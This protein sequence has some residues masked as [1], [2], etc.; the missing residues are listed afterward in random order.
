MEGP[1]ATTIKSD[2]RPPTRATGKRLN[3]AGALFE[4]LGNLIRAKPGDGTASG[5]REIAQKRR[6][7]F[8]E[9]ARVDLLLIAVSPLPPAIRT[10]PLAATGGTTRTATSSRTGCL[11][12]NSTATPAPRSHWNTL[13]SVL[14]QPYL[15]SHRITPPFGSTIAYLIWDQRHGRAIAQH[16]RTWR[17]RGGDRRRRGEKISESPNIVSLAGYSV[18]FVASFEDW[19]KH[20]APRLGASL[21]FY[22][23]LSLA[24]LLLVLVS[25]VGLVLG[26]KRRKQNVA[27]CNPS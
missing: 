24:P 21:A 16:S 3:S 22:T 5:A 13:G 8:G 7:G 6:Q 26:T 14:K 9:A 11:S 10:I 15:A 12:T 17:N 4:D 23:L 19:S 18:H 27:Q 2:A 25:V 1:N 20:K